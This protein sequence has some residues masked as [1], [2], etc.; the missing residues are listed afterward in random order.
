MVGEEFGE[1][2][3]IQPLSLGDDSTWRYSVGAEEAD[4][5]L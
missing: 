5:G 4:E 2:E 3:V 1:Q